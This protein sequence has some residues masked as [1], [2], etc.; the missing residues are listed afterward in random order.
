MTSLLAGCASSSVQPLG[1]S[2]I[3]VPIEAAQFVPV[4]PASPN[5][6]QVAVLSGD[7]TSGPSAMLMR[8]RKGGGTPHIHSSDYQLVV[9]Q[10][11]MKH[12]GKG[13][14]AADGKPLNPG[15]YWFQPGGKT[16][17]DPCLTDECLLFIVWAGKRDGRLPTEGDQ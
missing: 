5:G 14:A 11:T 9:L 10:G 6:T 16:H 7:P 12:L 13:Q 3:V 17:A 1:E 2:M 8:L 15:S 4:D